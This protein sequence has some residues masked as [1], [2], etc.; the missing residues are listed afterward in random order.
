MEED[1]KKI[2]LVSLVM[3]VMLGVVTQA[4]AWPRGLH[5]LYRYEPPKCCEQKEAVD[6]QSVANMIEK[7]RDPNS[8]RDDYGHDARDHYFLIR[9]YAQKLGLTLED[10]GVSDDG[11]K[12]MVRERVME[13]SAERMKIV[14]SEAISILSMI[15]EGGSREKVR[16]LIFWDHR[17]DLVSINELL[18]N[19]KQFGITQKEVGLWEGELDALIKLESEDPPRFM[20][21]R[22]RWFCK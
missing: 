16:P 6:K 4:F 18:E 11:L 19:G 14:R 22:W 7:L 3:A 20:A 9:C 10:F 21:M 2:G 1:M 12:K 17:Q 13:A 8:S 5:K 15:K